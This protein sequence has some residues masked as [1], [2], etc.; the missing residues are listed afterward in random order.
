MMSRITLNLRSSGSRR[1]YITPRAGGY[2]RKT[3][4]VCSDED[5]RSMFPL[6]VITN[7]NQTRVSRMSRSGVGSSI[8]FGMLPPSPL[9]PSFSMGGRGSPSVRSY[10]GYPPPPS[11]GILITSHTE[12]SHRFSFLF[13][14]LLSPFSPISL[15]LSTFIFSFSSGV[16]FLSLPLFCVHSLPIRPTDLPRISASRRREL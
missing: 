7:P 14:P 9:S 15:S 1:S 13:D 11:P 5:G 2:I 6:E 4:D 10:G 8:R 12:V 16:I 3:T